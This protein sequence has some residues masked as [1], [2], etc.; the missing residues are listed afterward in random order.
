MTGEQISASWY[1]GIT[2]ARHEGFAR[3]DGAGSLVLTE[4]DDT[5]TSVPLSDLVFGEKLT[6]ETVY[7]RESLPDFRLRLPGDVPPEF[8]AALPVAAKYGGWVDRMGL[9]KAV[10]AFGVASAGAVALFMTAPEWLGP[11]VPNAWERQIG[12]AMVGD[13]KVNGAA[14]S[15]PAKPS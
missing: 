14:E 7:K 12:D 11:L 15:S 5:V 13:A 8:A 1:D 9:G 2:A 4:R 6:G 3:L 10:I